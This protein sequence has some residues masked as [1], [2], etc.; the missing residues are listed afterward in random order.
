MIV[1]TAERAR[2]RTGPFVGRVERARRTHTRIG[3]FSRGLAVRRD[4]SGHGLQRVVGRRGLL[5][6]RRKLC[7]RVDHDGVR[8]NRGSSDGHGGG[9]GDGRVIGGCDRGAIGGD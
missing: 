3:P 2:M 5:N 1:G 8:G 7:R 9:G 4:Y 6:V